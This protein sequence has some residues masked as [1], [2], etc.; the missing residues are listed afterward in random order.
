[1]K[2][3]LIFA[4][5]L[6]LTSCAY[7]K[8]EAPAPST[9]VVTGPKITYTDHTKKL[10]DTYC[11]TCHAPLLTQANFPLTSYSEVTFGNY[12][13]IGGIIEKRV[14]IQQNMPPS[15]SQA[16][17]LTPA[18]MDTLQMWIDQGAPQ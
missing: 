11:I 3:F 17:Q 9:P 16:G 8:D 5:I 14:L 15:G 18:E 7:N 4:A 6:I 2:Q 10:F 13:S 12:A 1:M